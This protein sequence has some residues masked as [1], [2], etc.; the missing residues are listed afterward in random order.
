VH[1]GLLDAREAGRTTAV[2]VLTAA[3]VPASL[4]TVLVAKVSD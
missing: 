3:G 1:D 4:A 2:T